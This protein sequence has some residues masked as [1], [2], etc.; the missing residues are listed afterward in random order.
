M[1]A[2]LSTLATY[3]ILR[4]SHWHLALTTDA[5]SGVQKFHAGPTPRIG[6][7]PISVSFALGLLYVYATSADASS[8]APLALVTAAPVFAVGLLEDI[9]KRVEPIARLV[10]MAASALVACLA[11]D[12]RI[13][14]LDFAPADALLASSGVSIAVTAIALIGVANAYNI[15]DGFNGLVG[16]V[17][18]MVLLSLAS[19][20]W[21]IG[22]AQI[23]VPALVLAGATLG[24]LV[25][26][27]PNGRIFAGD[28]GAY[29][30]GFVI[31]L[32]SVMLAERHENVSAW[33]P[34]A[35]SIY[36]VWETVF[37]IYRR[38]LLRGKAAMRPDAL[39]LHTLIYRRLC[40]WNDHEALADATRR[41]SLTSPYLWLLTLPFMAIS[42][43]FWDSVVAQ[44]A[45]IVGFVLTYLTLYW[46][47]VRFR[48]PRWITVRFWIGGQRSRRARI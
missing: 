43:A 35:L 46:R 32:L 30:V 5:S 6:G 37:T 8:L 4:C 26:N 10:V 16:M 22:D 36:P 27:F 15:I 20:A 47:I 18:V 9:T 2:V 31:A 25:W 1:C 23:A 14:S 24:F 11:F 29:F 33:L 3:V 17:S 34:L 44:Q 41:N 48:T 19:V 45:V 13:T 21:T 39:H 38:K 7:V 42:L 12:L 28:G 40:R